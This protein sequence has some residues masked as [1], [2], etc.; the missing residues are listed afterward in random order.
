MYCLTEWIE[1]QLKKEHTTTPLTNNPH[2]EWEMDGKTFRTYIRCLHDLCKFPVIDVCMISV[3]DKETSNLIITD[4]DSAIVNQ[5]IG[6]IELVAR[7]LRAK[8][9][10]TEFQHEDEIEYYRKRGYTIQKNMVDFW[11]YTEPSSTQNNPEYDYKFLEQRLAERSL[12][13]NV[14][15]ME[16]FKNF[17]EEA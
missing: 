5:Y 15:Y 2:T 10:F 9:R 16:A 13:R 4:V 3:Q 14:W 6:T 12:S 11:F 17:C 8:L 7:K 1:R